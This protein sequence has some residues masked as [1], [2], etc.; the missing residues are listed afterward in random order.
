ME[1]NSGTRLGH[2]EVRDR[3][4]KGGMGEVYRAR[5]TK[6]NRD[7]ALKVL[8]ADLAADAERRMRFERE[9][10]AV[11]ALNHPNIVTIHSVEQADETHFITMELVEGKTL[12]RLIPQGG[13]PLDRI[14]DIAVP[15]ADALAAAH[16]KG[17]THRDLKPDNVMVTDEGR[18]KVLD[19][20]LA[21]LAD[22]ADAMGEGATATVTAEGKILGTVAYMSPEQ[23][24]GRPIDV[25]SDVFSLGV[26]LYEMAGG[27]RPFEGDTRISTITS[28]LRDAPLP[29]TDVRHDLPR[30]LSR[31]VNRCLAKE[32]DRRYQ[33]AL[34]VRNELDEL[35]REVASGE[36]E[37]SSTPSGITSAPDVPPSTTQ[38]RVGPIVGILAIVALAV[39][40]AIWLFS[41]ESPAPVDTPGAGDRTG[42]VAVLGFENLGDPSDAE[43][44]SRM[45]VGLITTGLADSGGI[46]VVSSAKVLTSLKEAG[47]T[48]GG[49]D[50]TLAA[51]AARGAGAGTM[52]V[53]QVMQSDERLLLTA[54]LVDVASGNTLG[55]M[56]AEGRG[57][58]DLFAMA[59]EIATEVYGKLGGD[60]VEEG[61]AIDLAQSL[62]DSP[63]AYRFY[64]AGELALHERRFEEAIE[65]LTQAIRSDPTFALAYY[66]L[67][68]AQL[69]YGDRG[70]ALRNLHN[71]LQYS[72][73][74]PPRWRTTYQAVID[75]EAGNVDNAYA[76]LEKLIAESPEMPDPYNYLGEI[77]THYSK[78]QDL[79]RAK[80]LFARALEL[81][82]TFKVV[83][84]HLTSFLLMYDELDE[85]RALLERY[86]DDTDPSVVELRVSLLQHERRFAEIVALEQDPSI[87][88]ALRDTGAFRDA[89]LRTGDVE[90]ALELASRNVEQSVGYSKGLALWE[91]ARL[92]I[93]AGRFRRALE[94]LEAG[95]SL[96]DSPVIHALG[97]SMQVTHA[98]VLELA[99]D[100]DAAIDRA[101]GARD[102]DYFHPRSRFDAAR[103]LF[104]AGRTDEADHEI[105]GLEVL[106]QD[107]R[108]PFHECWL[109]LARAERQ[110]ALGNP[111]EALSMLSR[112]VPRACKPQT[113]ATREL[114]LARAAEDAGDLEQALR[115][116]RTLADPPWPPGSLVVEWDIAAL[117]EV[118]RL[119]QSTGKFDDARRHYREFLEHWGDADMPVPIVERARE[120]FDA[121]GGS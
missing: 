36:I 15:L 59:G 40:G 101:R 41:R 19:F 102:K 92:N 71:G 26:L 87:A 35:R 85:A 44:F 28:I 64:V 75:Y 62:T 51:E 57:K 58:S 47:A 1:L 84:F 43:Q 114:L 67:A 90:R 48:G 79:L 103:L 3:L 6:L 100:I 77:L 113:E 121:L 13:I 80:E 4:G 37:M 12:T 107:S 49:F 86:H 50:P 118:A 99:G 42:P 94:D 30:H 91:R 88:D 73:R 70:G 53:G 111:A 54:E 60:R 32:P 9:A 115:H 82:P 38:R 2:Y 31:I 104:A 56:R 117:Y 93:R 109:E 96:Y 5:D 33:S 76:A 95:P 29:L 78:Y 18:V 20:G 106:A 46:E 21:K 112:D 65:Q 74:L 105:E 22:S 10:Q 119:E 27:S 14:F 8:P 120:Q 108:S 55:S 39:L 69:W 23:A 25:R 24:A 81:D 63:E 72:D 7:V 66:D 34:D 11:A 110:R 17:I 83:L 68:T 45:L 116:F 61:L 16:G 97:A 89:L 98:L 52:V